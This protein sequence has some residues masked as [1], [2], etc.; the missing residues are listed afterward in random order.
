MG[1]GFHSG[2]EAVRCDARG[3]YAS[4]FTNAVRSNH[5]GSQPRSTSPGPYSIRMAIA[6]ALL[7]LTTVAGQWDSSFTKL[8]GNA[9]VFHMIG[10]YAFGPQDDKW[11]GVL[12]LISRSVFVEHRVLVL[13]T[14]CLL[15]RWV[16]IQFEEMVEEAEARAIRR[17]IDADPDDYPP[18]RGRPI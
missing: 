17:L 6:H 14:W 5:F 8:I 12:A 16:T 18:R 10:H 11:C 13:D 4:C 15:Q 9:E 3:R 7:A 2:C 1:I